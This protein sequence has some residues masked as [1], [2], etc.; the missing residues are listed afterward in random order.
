MEVFLSHIDAS[1]KSDLA[2]TNFYDWMKRYCEQ[3]PTNTAADMFKPAADLY[4]KLNLRTKTHTNLFKEL[5]IKIKAEIGIL[6]ET[7]TS[8]VIYYYYLFIF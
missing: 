1:N 3:C 2:L 8:Q 5:A 6:D 4:F 7:A